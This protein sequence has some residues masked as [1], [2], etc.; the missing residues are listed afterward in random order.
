MMSTRDKRLQMQLPF[1]PPLK[2]DVCLHCS[3][4]TLSICPKC[5]RCEDCG[6]A[7]GCD[8]EFIKL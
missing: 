7:K 2:G 3:D 4:V 8:G 6:H 1:N 5:M